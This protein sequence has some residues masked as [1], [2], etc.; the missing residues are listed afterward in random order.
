M[1][2]AEEKRRQSDKLIEL[3]EISFVRANRVLLHNVSLTVHR[4]QFMTIIGPNG[5]GKS[6]LLSVLLGL[7][8]PTSGMIHRHPSLRYG[9]MP[10][11]LVLDPSLPLDVQTFLSL[12]RRQRAIGDVL[13]E[14]GA[15]HLAERSMHVL[16][17]GEMQRVL[18]ARALLND[19]E[20]LVLDEPT[21]ALDIMAQAHFYRLL[22]QTRPRLK[23]AVVLVSHD[24]H[25]VH[26]SSD[27]VICLNHHIC[28]AGKPQQVRSHQAYQH[29]F[30]EAEAQMVAPYTHSHDHAHDEPHVHGEDCHV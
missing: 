26:A 20:I 15:Q 29:L 27:Q 14:V 21:Q 9:Y 22:N 4:G 11:R 7:E 30:G 2:S 10:Q 8:Q 5:A 25:F 18:L 16:S 17:G 23:M 1:M 6:T 3:E 19:P 28:C 13:Q 24:L 12:A